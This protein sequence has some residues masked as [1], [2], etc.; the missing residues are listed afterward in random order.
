MV[1][2]VTGPDQGRPSPTAP[3]AWIADRIAE[4]TQALAPSA[5]RASPLASMN[6]KAEARLQRGLRLLARGERVLTD[7]LHV[8][9]LCTL[10]G[11]PHVVLDNSYAKLTSFITTWPADGMTQIA[12]SIGTARAMLAPDRG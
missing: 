4:I 11:I 1:T 9:I 7:R 12:D 8:H 5:G 10:M 6:R 3:T 2:G